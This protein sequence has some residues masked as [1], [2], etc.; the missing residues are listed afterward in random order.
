MG[1]AEQ[2]RTSIPDFESLEE[3]AAFWD[4]HS[5]ADF[6]DELEPVELEVDHPIGHILSV[7]LESEEFR[8][9]SALAKQRGLTTTALAQRWVL[10]ALAQAEVPDAEGGDRPAAPR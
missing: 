2:T 8:R 1:Q 10:E 6:K 7:R 9:L 3:E 4:S 5:L